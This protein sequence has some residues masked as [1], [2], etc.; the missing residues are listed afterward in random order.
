LVVLQIGKYKIGK[1]KE[2][3]AKLSSAAIRGDF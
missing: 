1:G 2:L 3:S